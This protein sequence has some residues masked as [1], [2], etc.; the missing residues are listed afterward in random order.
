MTELHYSEKW[1]HGASNRGTTEK[2][3]REYQGRDGSFLVRDSGT[4]IGNYS[5][6][7]L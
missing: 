1:F 3:L 5:L 6:S 2:L 4:F 7:F